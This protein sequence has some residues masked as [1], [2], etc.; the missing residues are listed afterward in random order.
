[1]AWITTCG[2]RLAFR[3]TGLGRRSIGSMSCSPISNDERGGFEEGRKAPMSIRVLREGEIRKAITM[4]E[5]IVAMEEAFAA[6]AR[7]EARLPDVINLDIPE[8]RGE[9]HVK[10][11]HFKGASQFAFKIASGFYDNPGKGLPSGSGLMLVF[12][13]ETGFPV[14]LL[15]DN[16]YLTDVR[17]G[18]AG[19]VA[20]KYLSN[21]VLNKVAVIGAGTQGRFQVRALS[22]VRKVPQVFVWD[23]VPTHAQRY[24]HE[25]AG[26]L[27]VEVSVASSI[28]EA[29]READLIITVTP[30][31]QPLVQA[32]WVSTG[33]HINAIGSDGP[34]KQELDVQVLAQADR[35]IADR[36]SQCLRLGEIHHAVQA[37]VI[38]VRDVAGE[39]GEVISGKVP[40]RTD[41]HQITVCDL[42]GVGVQDAAIAALAY[43][44][45]L[46]MGVGESIE[47]E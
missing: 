7:G 10:G 6:L 45:A 21:P 11:A 4:D 24:A 38:S 5:A 30:S 32:D 15:L 12:D 28:E 41:D 3:Q 16:G 37:G 46:K 39:L 18:A 1:M 17:T 44:N 27:G 22:V 8:V 43:Q 29:V 33:A 9:V 36:L 35:I 13:A 25:M 14:A 42:T 26:E 19:A 23:C 34:E 40:G 2:S 20:A 31:R 47:S